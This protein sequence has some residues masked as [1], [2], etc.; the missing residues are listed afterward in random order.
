MSSVGT[1]RVDGAVHEMVA[2]LTPH[3]GVDW[4][5]PDGSLEWSCWQTAAHVAH[6]LLAYAGQIAGRADAGYLPFDLVI[7]PEASPRGCDVVGV[8]EQCR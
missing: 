2:V 4:Q 1:E 3:D 8:H 5:V 6:D 7:S